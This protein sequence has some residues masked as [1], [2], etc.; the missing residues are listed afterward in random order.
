MVRSVRGLKAGGIFRLEAN[1]PITP[2]A[3]AVV[4][5]GDEWD[6]WRTDARR[7][8]TED[9]ER[10][11][12]LRVLVLARGFAGDRVSRHAFVDREPRGRGRDAK[13]S[14]RK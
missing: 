11:Q 8:A 12:S 2:Q 3:P 1:P 14:A 7:L 9:T 10:T 4:Q 6:C 13:H 5:S